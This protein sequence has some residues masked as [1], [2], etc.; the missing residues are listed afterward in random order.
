[1]KVSFTKADG[2]MIQALHGL[3][4]FILSYFVKTKSTL[5]LLPHKCWVDDYS[6]SVQW[7]LIS[8]VCT[9]DVK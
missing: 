2:L 9:G 8:H 3:F 1:M 7:A 5:A 6:V 4:R